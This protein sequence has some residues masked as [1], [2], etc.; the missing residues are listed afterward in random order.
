MFVMCA[1]GDQG[2]VTSPTMLCQGC[3]Y[4][5]PA[6]EEDKDWKASLGVE[7]DPS[8][9]PERCQ[10]TIHRLIRYSLLHYPTRPKQGL[11]KA[12]LSLVLEWG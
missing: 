2:L 11:I 8:P 4:F 5:E 7:L 3:T 1:G 6:G 12:Y 9:T 10:T